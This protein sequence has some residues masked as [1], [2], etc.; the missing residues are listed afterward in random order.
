VI[1]PLGVP[2]LTPA[3]I[4]ALVAFMETLTDERVVYRRAPFDHPQL[5]VPNGHPGNSSTTTDEN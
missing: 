2:A 3:E 4:D 1:E 5:F